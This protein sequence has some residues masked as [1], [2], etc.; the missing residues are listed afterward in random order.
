MDIEATSR[1]DITLLADTLDEGWDVI[2]TVGLPVGRIPINLD[3]GFDSRMNRKNVFNA[4]LWP[5]IK[6]N[7]RNRKPAPPKRGRPRLWDEAVYALRFAVER[8]VA[9]ED[10]FR[11]LLIRFEPK[12]AHFLGF[13]HLA[14]PLINLRTFVYHGPRHLFCDILLHAVSL[15]MLIQGLPWV[16]YNRKETGNQFKQCLPETAEVHI[17]GTSGK[18]YT[19]NLWQKIQRLAADLY[20]TVIITEDKFSNKNVGDDG[21]DIIG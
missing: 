13:K 2:R 10:K 11:H 17:F 14:Y 6:E 15:L 4:G 9:W 20:E 12:K 19:G 3:S 1:P 7:P 18:R 16:V 8:T 21:L 5:N